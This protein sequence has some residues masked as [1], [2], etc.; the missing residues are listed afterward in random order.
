MQK[1]GICTIVWNVAGKNSVT[2]L[3]CYCLPSVEVLLVLAS[4]SLLTKAADTLGL[5]IFIAFG[6]PVKCPKSHRTLTEQLELKFSYF[7]LI[8]SLGNRN[9]QFAEPTS[10]ML[11]QLYGVVG[12][13]YKALKLVQK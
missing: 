13:L 9:E 3:L 7:W 2:P 12:L 4:S 6:I 8:N 1:K 5:V 10:K 11:F